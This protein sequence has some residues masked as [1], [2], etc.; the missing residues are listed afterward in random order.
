MRT[1]HFKYVLIAKERL[2]GRISAGQIGDPMFFGF[3]QTTEGQNQFALRGLFG[4]EKGLKTGGRSLFSKYRSRE[5]HRCAV[6]K[7]LGQ[8]SQI[9]SFVFAVCA[10]LLDNHLDFLYEITFRRLHIQTVALEIGERELSDGVRLRC[11]NRRRRGLGCRARGGFRGRFG[12]GLG[13]R[14]R[15]RRRCRLG[16]GFRRRFRRRHGRRFRVFALVGTFLTQ[17]QQRLLRLPAHADLKAAVFAEGLVRIADK[18]I[19]RLS[20][21]IEFYMLFSV[22]VLFGCGLLQEIRQFSLVVVSEGDVRE[23]SAGLK[24]KQGAEERAEDRL[25]LFF[26]RITSIVEGNNR[27]VFYAHI[28]LNHRGKYKRGGH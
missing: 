4:I 11:W 7:S 5:I 13:C 28:I 27:S 10:L 25:R 16:C 19:D 24:Q 3:F 23:H 26:H 18:F 14:G 15:F 12:R 22:R 20:V 8:G 21:F 6:G 1:D 2:C 9:L 17:P